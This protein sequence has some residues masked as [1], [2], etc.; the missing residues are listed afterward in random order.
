MATVSHH[1]YVSS[2]FAH[3]DAS[4]PSS[5]LG[6]FNHGDCVSFILGHFDHGD[7]VPFVLS[8]FGHGDHVPLVLSDFNPD[9]QS[10]LSNFL[11]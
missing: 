8:G 7:H 2:D 3:C 6:D 1:S 11:F 5:I 9:D 4:R 10:R